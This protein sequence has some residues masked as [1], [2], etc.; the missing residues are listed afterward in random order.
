[1]GLGW[2]GNEGF[3]MVIYVVIGEFAGY[4]SVLQ[5][6]PNPAFFPPLSHLH[7]CPLVFTLLFNKYLLRAA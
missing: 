5:F 3:Y 4:D 6:E 2:I 1:M 7:N